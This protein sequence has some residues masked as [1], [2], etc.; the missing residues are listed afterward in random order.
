[1]RFVLMMVL[2]VMTALSCATAPTVPTGALAQGEMRL[3]K[4][5]PP[6]GDVLAN[7]TQVFDINFEADGHP[8]VKRICIYLSG[9]GPY[10]SNTVKRVNYGSQANIEVELRLKPPGTYT[11]GSYQLECYAEYLRDGRTVRT[12][13]VSTHINVMLK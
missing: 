13:M 6:F 4:I 8:S 5:V 3:L 11:Y 12:N 10:C 1:M 9:D 7:I 2:I